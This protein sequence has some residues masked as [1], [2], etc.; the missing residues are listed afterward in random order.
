MAK[1]IITFYNQGNKKTFTKEIDRVTFAEAATFAYIAK[2]KDSRFET[3]IIS[4][5]KLHNFNLTEE[6]TK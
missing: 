6:E 4:I 1:Y 5:V 3:E 2:S